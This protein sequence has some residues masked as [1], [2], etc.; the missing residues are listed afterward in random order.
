MELVK[1]VY[2]NDKLINT[3]DYVGESAYKELSVLFINAYNNFNDHSHN[4]WNVINSNGLHEIK[5]EQRFG[6]G[7]VYT[8]HFTGEDVEYLPTLMR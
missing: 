4:I 7:Y 1:K 8:Y 5:A 2:Y 6:N 3:I